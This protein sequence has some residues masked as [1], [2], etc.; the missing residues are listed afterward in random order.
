MTRIGLAP[1]DSA[2]SCDS[3][4]SAT[5]TIVRCYVMG[6][7]RPPIAYRNSFFNSGKRF[8]KVD[9]S[10]KD[11]RSCGFSPGNWEGRSAV[12]LSLAFDRP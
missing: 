5:A 7:L 4:M 2:Y 6:D 8:N 11:Q 9:N 3:A 10:T 12:R 1:E